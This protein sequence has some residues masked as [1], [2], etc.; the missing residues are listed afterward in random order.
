MNIISVA[1]VITRI[2]IFFWQTLFHKLHIFN[3][4]NKQGE[5]IVLRID[6]IV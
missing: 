6:K 5:L 3:K 1:S 2:V 4:Q